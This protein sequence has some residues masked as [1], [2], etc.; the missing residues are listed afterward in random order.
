[1]EFVQLLKELN[2]HDGCT[3]QKVFHALKPMIIEKIYDLLKNRNVRHTGRPITT[4]FNKF[5]DALFFI[6][7]SGSQFKYVQNVSGISKGTFYR[8]LKFFTDHQLL[9]NIYQSAIKYYPLIDPLIT[10]TFTV[11]SMSGNEGLGR[12][13]TDRGRKGFK[14]SLISD[15]NRVVR[16]VQ[17]AGANK[18]DSKILVDTID[19]MKQPEHMVNCLCDAGYVGKN[20]RDTCHSKNF[21]LIV[22]PK[23]T[24]KKGNMSHILLR[25]DAELLHMK[26]N[27]IELLNGQ[28][29]RF[30]GLMI[31][32]V[33]H[34]SIYLSFLYVA[35]LSITCYQIFVNV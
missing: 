10:D 30:R 24:N 3:F 18:H 23:K 34:M 33:R 27:Q 19:Q 4:D 9:Q 26:R 25:K 20:L 1:M 28:I 16:A 22:K 32:W 15:A 21:R 7:E 29:R 8:Y 2:H 35:L 31:K 6:S 11:K 13:P 14:V 17:I 12:N 5:L